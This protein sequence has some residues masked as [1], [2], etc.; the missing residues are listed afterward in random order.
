MRCLITK[1]LGKKGLM[2][3]NNYEE[4]INTASVDLLFVCVPN[5]LSPIV[6]IAGLKEGMHVFL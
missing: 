2:Y 5:Y 6:T 3:F 4:L 1:S